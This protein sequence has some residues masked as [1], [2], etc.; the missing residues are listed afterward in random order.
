MQV[1]RGDRS[2]QSTLVVLVFSVG[3]AHAF[4]FSKI[5]HY[6]WRHVL[7]NTVPLFCSLRC[8][9]SWYSLRYF[10]FIT[11]RRS[12]HV[13]VLCRL[14]LVG[15]QCHDLV[16]THVLITLDPQ[17]IILFVAS[18]KMRYLLMLVVKCF[19]LNLGT[20]HLRGRVFKRLSRIPTRLKKVFMLIMS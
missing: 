5:V 2:S 9:R 19:L 12:T 18:V 20:L 17:F 16:V 4:S 11:I 10:H 3:W 8:A 14:E 13:Q 1:S 7:K 15:R 6:W